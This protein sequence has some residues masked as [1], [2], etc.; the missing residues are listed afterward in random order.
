MQLNQ[1]KIIV[2]ARAPQKG[3]VKTRLARSIGDEKAL[4]VYQKMLES[5]LCEAIK[6]GHQVCCYTDQPGHGYFAQWQQQGIIF[7]RQHGED[8]GSRMLNAFSQEQSGEMPVLLMG[9][10][11]PQ[12]SANVIEKVIDTLA[13]KRQVVIVPSDDGGYV[14]IAFRNQVYRDLFEDISWSSE[15]VLAQTIAKLQ[16]LELPYSLLEPLMDIDTAE[17][18]E[19]W[20]SIGQ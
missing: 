13:S 15:K 12:M 5:T 9:S 10:D 16:A 4:V 20:L 8:I 7:Y 6:S 18:Y 19:R 2:F 17:D 1:A 3:R 14:L 11:C